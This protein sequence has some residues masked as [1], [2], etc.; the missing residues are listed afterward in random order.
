MGNSASASLVVRV[1]EPAVFAGGSLSGTVYL[2]VPAPTSA[3]VLQL[4]ISGIERAH[5]HWT[6]RGKNTTHHHDAHARELCA[7]AHV[8]K[9]CVH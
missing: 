2:G 1:N 6:T 3:A 5:T 4:S 9:K 8:K 7:H